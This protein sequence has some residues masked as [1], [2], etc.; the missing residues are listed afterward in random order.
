MC[1]AP[2]WA[3]RTDTGSYARCTATRT[4]VVVIRQPALTDPF[5]VPATFDCPAIRQRYGTGN[6]MMRMRAKAARICISKF[7]PYV[8]SRIG[9]RA[10]AA[11]LIATKAAHVAV[12]R[13]R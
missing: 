2:C 4:S 8:V 3:F 10:R 1:A 6:S 7:Q 12:A 11:V 5:K 13:A 9:S